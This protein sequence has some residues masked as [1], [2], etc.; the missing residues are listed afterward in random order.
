MIPKSF[1]G[2]IFSIVFII[3][4]GIQLLSILYS[5]EGDQ[6]MSGC[7]KSVIQY[8]VIVS[9]ESGYLVDFVYAIYP[10]NQLMQFTLG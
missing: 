4:F 6:Y 10:P 9:S 8:H 3:G 7:L 5:Q 1:L 2:Q